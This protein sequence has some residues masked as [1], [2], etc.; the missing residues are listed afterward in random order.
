M[1]SLVPPLFLLDPLLLG[2]MIWQLSF[3]QFST[4]NVFLSFVAALFYL[5]I[6]HKNLNGNFFVIK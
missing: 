1:A 2:P 4:V 5:L 6:I 3:V